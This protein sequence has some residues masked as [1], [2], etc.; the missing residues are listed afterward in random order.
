MTRHTFSVLACGLVAGLLLG[1]AGASMLAHAGPSRTTSPHLVVRLHRM[2]IR[3]DQLAGYDEWQ[4]FLHDRHA[5]AVRTLEREHMFV[6]AMFR[7]ADDPHTLYWL[8]V[9]DDRGA[10]VESSTDDLDITHQQF[11]D[12]VL[13][14]GSGS[15]MSTDNLLVAPFIAQAIQT[16]GNPTHA[17]P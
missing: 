11:M 15:V 2:S 13:Q 4:A 17:N 3:N 1:V 7:S 16:H 5:D 14:P 10:P 8:E 9:R 12:R 6:E